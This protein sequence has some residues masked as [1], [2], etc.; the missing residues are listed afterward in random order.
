MSDLDIKEKGKTVPELVNF[1]DIV[2][3]IIFTVC[4]VVQTIE[5]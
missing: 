2:F 1:D 5:I 3:I 4:L